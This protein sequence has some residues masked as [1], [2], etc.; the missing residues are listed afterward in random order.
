[1]PGV[2]FSSHSNAFGVRRSASSTTSGPTRAIT[3][4]VSSDCMPGISSVRVGTGV[5]KAAV[6]TPLK[7]ATVSPSFAT[8]LATSLAISWLTGSSGEPGLARMLESTWLSLAVS[9]AVGQPF[10]RDTVSG[11]VGTCAGL[12]AAR[13]AV[14][15]GEVSSATVVGA[16]G[17][18]VVG[19]LGSREGGTIGPPARR[20]QERPSRGKPPGFH[21]S[22]ALRQF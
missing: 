10:G 9:F 5:S 2:T 18:H 22:A 1:M 21:G 8:A 19:G 6:T 17:G 15:G 12:T 14:G 20:S 4:A 3:I 16:C 11:M 7:G 13:G